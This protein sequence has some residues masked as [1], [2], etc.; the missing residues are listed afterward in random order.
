MKVLTA[1][2]EKPAFAKAISEFIIRQKSSPRRKKRANGK[3]SVAIKVSCAS[4]IRARLSRGIILIERLNSDDRR[5][6][7]DYG[8]LL[9]L[10]FCHHATVSAIPSSEL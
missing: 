9:S 10:I 2:A 6:L 4:A 5:L 3:D 8:S 7:Q 1:M